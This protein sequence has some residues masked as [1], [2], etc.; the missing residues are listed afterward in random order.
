MIVLISYS[1]TFPD[2]QVS[3]CL[4]LYHDIILINIDYD[5]VAVPIRQSGPMDPQLLASKKLHEMYLSFLQGKFSSHPFK[6]ELSIPPLPEFGVP[7]TFNFYIY[8]H[9]NND[10]NQ[11]KG[12]RI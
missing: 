2:L 10:V 1:R 12:Q 6:Y 4:M 7:G 11:V 9:S 5:T 8:F 3:I